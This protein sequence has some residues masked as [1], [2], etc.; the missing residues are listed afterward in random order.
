MADEGN[1]F[2]VNPLP[3][4]E[5]RVEQPSTE[6]TSGSSTSVLS[7]R[8]EEVET[9]RDLNLADA[10]ATAHKE[11]GLKDKQSKIQG[12]HDQAMYAEAGRQATLDQQ[13]TDKANGDIAAAKA[14]IEQRQKVLDNTHP[15][16]WFHHGDTWGNALRGLGL[17]L[18][19][20]GDATQKSA[21][22]RIGQV[23]HVNTVGEI[24]DH[25][26]KLQEQHIAGLKDSVVQAHTGLADA[27]EARQQM[28]ADRKQAAASAYDRLIKLAA[29]RMSALG[30]D[31]NQINESKEV[32]ALREKRNDK[33]AE[34]VAPTANKIEKHFT[35]HG[36][37]VEE[38]NRQPTPQTGPKE[39]Q[40]KLAD[41]SAGMLE[42]L[43]TI[44]S[45]PPLTQDEL[46][47]IQ[48]NQIASN[49]ADTA[50]GPLGVIG[51]K[52][53]RA[54]G[55][56]PR[57]KYEGLKPNAQKSAN[58]WDSLVELRARQLTGAGMPEQEAIREA[59]T[60]GYSPGDSPQV[61]QQKITRLEDAAK[62]GIKL[63]GQGGAMVTP[64]A[65]GNAAAPPA[66]NM[67]V[68]PTEPPP[69]VPQTPAEVT[70]N[71][72][73]GTPKLQA[74]QLLKSGKVS[75]GLRDLTMRKFGITQE[76]LR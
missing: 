14:R 68:A 55:I 12:E 40:A 66:P 49:A 34:V 41:L 59:R 51:G 30:M 22:A 19:T 50:T 45:Q 25:D 33:L 63:S 44:K 28:L 74:I 1:T 18:A 7:P 9:H 71:A 23:S 20:V 69:F 67:S 3:E 58:A 35:Q 64:P 53:G 70:A 61:M 76:D 42:E 47:S 57:T 4:Y 65:G 32:Q 36:A 52:V 16:G 73:P 8:Q 48:D 75:S 46:N 5:K 56:T 72:K 26:L 60:L 13:A 62:R 54:V 15:S 39:A 24:I 38:V 2:V 43:N 37:K 11:R 17:A 29:A 31:N 10:E 21:A 27:N 6:S